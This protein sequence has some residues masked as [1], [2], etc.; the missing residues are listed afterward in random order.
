MRKTSYYSKYVC[1]PAVIS[2]LSQ[3]FEPYSHP[4]SVLKLSAWGQW[5][6]PDNEETTVNKSCI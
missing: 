1:L 4:I 6:L 3:I 2:D 5:H